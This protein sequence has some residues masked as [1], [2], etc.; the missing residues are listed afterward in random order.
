MS[1]D[2]HAPTSAGPA[3]PPV[4]GPPGATVA[5]PTD[6]AATS[7]GEGGLGAKASQAAEQAQQLT[8]E[9]PEVLVGAAFAGG[10]VAAMILKRLGR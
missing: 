4:A 5:P 10:F 3:P 6:T 1:E 9:R 2:L 7:D 8:A